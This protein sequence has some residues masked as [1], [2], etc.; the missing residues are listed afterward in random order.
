[1]YSYVQFDLL[2]SVFRQIK[3]QTAKNLSM[4]TMQIVGELQTLNSRLDIF[5]S[6][7]GKKG[8]FIDFH[9]QRN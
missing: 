1:M 4:K 5:S 9:L 3:I 2:L 8:G 6:V 7:L